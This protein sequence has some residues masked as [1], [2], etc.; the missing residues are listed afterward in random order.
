MDALL[1]AHSA[2]LRAQWQK[3][4]FTFYSYT[5][6]TQH[7]FFFLSKYKV[8]IVY[9]LFWRICYRSWIEEKLS[10]KLECYCVEVTWLI[11]LT[12]LVL[13]HFIFFLFTSPY[14]ERHVNVIYIVRRLCSFCCR[15]KLCL[16]WNSVF[17][18]QYG[19]HL[20]KNPNAQIEMNN[21]WK[22]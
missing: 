11:H 17:F 19:I 20:R 1:V 7:P 8:H 4:L 21:V 13:L 6:N 16:W 18:H 5:L 3:K 12:A 9:A 14:L 22:N 15:F 2:E 10:L